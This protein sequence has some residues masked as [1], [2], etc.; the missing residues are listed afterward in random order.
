MSILFSPLKIGNTTLPNRI[1][2]APMC[3][4]S[5]VD[6]SMT[7]WHIM[8][9]GSMALSG[10]S[11]LVIEAAGVVPEGRITPQC[12]GLYSDANE[13][14]LARVMK[15][16]RSISPIVTGIQLAHAGRKASSHRP[17]NGRGPLKPNEGAWQCVAPS[18][19]ALAT[20]WPVPHALTREEMNRAKEAWVAAAKRAARVGLDF[21]EVHS[22]H[23]YLFS[24]F[25]SPLSN[26]R[27]DEYGGSLQNRMRWPLEVFRA[28]RTA[29]P[30]DK[31]I[32]AK[33]SG[34]DFVPG[35]WSPDDAVVYAG[36]LKKAGADYVTVSGGGVV[37]D[38]QVPVAPGYQV[39]FA[40]RV[41]R[42][43]GICTG[44]VGL[45]TDPH[46]AEAVLAA[47]Q[48]DFISIARALLF[49]PRWG[50]HAAVALG[51]DDA[52]VPYAKQYDRGSPRLWPPGKTM[53]KLGA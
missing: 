31:F 2:V 25:L 42:E 34:S 19:V 7:D 11:M 47:G 50:Q 49:N 38:A 8:H 23:G 33:I 29:W 18:E 26:K 36:E 12:V 13:E 22:T 15:F 9:L 16:V 10:A 48:A 3:Q 51:A 46:Q 40:E 45:I 30:A 6:G 43:T 21:I 35:A 41:K 32:G 28:M 24:E 1:S 37:L 4:Y 17:W 14:A 53:G 44:A 52:G 27:T 39:P 5:A 20:D